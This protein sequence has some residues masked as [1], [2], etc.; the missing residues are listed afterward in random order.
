MNI[1]IKYGITITINDDELVRWDHEK[2]T[3]IYSLWLKDGSR[4]DYLVDKKIFL[5]AN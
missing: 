4:W 1:K 5:K 2:I 3:N